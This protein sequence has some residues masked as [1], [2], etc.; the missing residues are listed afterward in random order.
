MAFIK[1]INAI[2][3]KQSHQVDQLLQL[4]DEAIY[5][6][7]DSEGRT[8]LH[9]ALQYGSNDI[10]QK[11]LNHLKGFP[12]CDRVLHIS[13]LEGRTPLHIAAAYCDKEG[14]KL[15]VDA[16]GHKINKATLKPTRQGK[17]AIDLLNDNK[18]SH[19]EVCIDLEDRLTKP[20]VI[21]PVNEIVD[22]ICLKDELAN[23]YHGPLYESMIYAHVAVSVARRAILQSSTH[24]SANQLKPEDFENLVYQCHDLRSSYNAVNQYHSGSSDESQITRLKSIVD[25]IKARKIGRCREYSYV[26]LDTLLR[27]GANLSNIEEYCIENG[28]HAF[29]VMNRD[30]NSN[31][32]DY[33][34]WNDSAV[35]IDAYSG[36]AYPAYEIPDRL[37]AFRCHQK[38][39]N[40]RVNVL[41]PFEPGYHKIQPQKDI[42][43]SK[44]Y[45]SSKQSIEK[46][47]FSEKELQVLTHLAELNNSNVEPKIE[48]EVE[49]K[50]EL[51]KD[52]SLTPTYQSDPSKDHILKT[53][54]DLRDYGASLLANKKE[55]ANKVIALANDIQNQVN[56]FYEAA[57]DKKVVSTNISKLVQNGKFA[58]GEDRRLRDIIGHIILALSVIGLI[59]MVAMK[60]AVGTLF[61]TETRRQNL[62]GKIDSQIKL[63]LCS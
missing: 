54:K 9:I 32:T 39:S 44:D 14:Y 59:V 34:T 36:A 33:K 26:V 13:D 5:A 37:F 46:D 7:T 23:K 42:H 24:P 60:I 1:L 51:P 30:P 56:H 49:P 35:V 3:S 20:Y 2:K 38:K 16:L 6:E 47:L 40:A 58:M 15:I 61:V 27:M 11:I 31:P 52:K 4:I 48:P 22:L 28:D 10:C 19:Q 25:K 41:I 17:L 53:I 55:K 21:P 50:I 12:C 29:V 43:L 8:I 45:I 18:N 62:V 63:K 57:S